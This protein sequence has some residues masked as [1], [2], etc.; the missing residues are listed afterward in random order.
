MTKVNSTE[1]SAATTNNKDY[2]NIDYN[3]D[4]RGGKSSFENSY[5]ISQSVNNLGK[6]MHL[7]FAEFSFLVSRTFND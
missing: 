2:Q 6:K 4:N 5:Q 7:G 1:M 3:D